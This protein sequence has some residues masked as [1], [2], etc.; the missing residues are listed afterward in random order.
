MHNT[1]S[2]K[3]RRYV[4]GLLII[5]LVSFGIVHFNQQKSS[6]VKSIGK[7]TLGEKKKKKTPEEQAMFAEE[8]LKHEFNLQANP[9]T[10]KIPQVEKNKEFQLASR[11]RTEAISRLQA[12]RAPGQD[13]ILRG[14][15]NLGGR[16]RSIIIDRADASGQTLIAGGVSS[17][18]FR[19]TDGGA[20]W[21]KVSA[22]S[23]IH[24]VTTIAQDPTNTN[25]WY[26]GTGELRGNSASLSG[27]F[28]YGQGIWQSTDG[29]LSWTQM[30]GTASTQEAFDSRFD[31]VVKVL[32][33]PTTGDIFA[34]T[35][36]TIYRYDQDTSTW[37]EE[38]A[39]PIVSST[40]Q[41]TDVVIA[42]DGSV[43]AAFSGASDA[44]V[45][46]VWT[47]PNGEGSWTRI[48]DT[49]SPSGW[50]PA[51]AGRIVLEAT[52]ANANIVYALYDNGRSSNSAQIESDFWRY[53][54]STGTWTDFSSKLPDEDGGAPGNDPF[55]IQGGYDLVVATKPDDANFVVIGGTNA[56]K[57][58]DIDADNTF[59][60]IGGYDGPNNYALY[61]RGGDTHHPDIHA[62]AFDPNNSSIM[63]SGT[64][65]GVHRTDDLDASS[66]AWTNLNNNYQTYQYYHVAMDPEAGS[67]IVIGG[68]QDNGTT[69]GGIDLGQP[70]STRMFTIFGGD[71]VSVAIS[72]DDD[73]LPFFLGS[74]LGQILRD[75]PTTADITPTGSSSQFVTYFYL[76]PDNNNALY[77]AGQATLYRTTDSNTVTAGS[78]D[79]VG[80]IANIPGGGTQEFIQSMATT[81]GAYTPQH[82][83]YIGGDEG[84]LYRLQDPQNASNLS[85]A[86]DITPPGV[87]RTFPNIVSGIATHPTNPDIVIASYSSYGVES[88]WLTTN[89]TADTPTWTNVERNIDAF[90]IR[91]VSITEVSNVTLY[92][93]GTARGLYAGVN[94]ETTDWVMQ[95]PDKVG[96]AVV[97]SLVSRPSDGTVLI[98]TH[99]NGMFEADA[100]TVLDSMTDPNDVDFDGIDN[101]SDNCPDFPNPDQADLDGDLLGDVCDDDIDGDGVLNDADNC[102]MMD[103]ADQADLDGD[104]IGDVCDED[105]DGDGVLNAFDLCP[106]TPQGATVDV[107]GCEI[108][109]LPSDNFSLSLNSET[110]RN[111]N[112]GSI[113][114]AANETFNY[115]A[116]LTGTSASDSQ[117]FTDT[118]TFDQLAADNYT[119]CITIDTEPDYEICFNANITEPAPLN[120]ATRVNNLDNT[121][122]VELSGSTSYTVDFNGQ[123]FTTNEQTLILQLVENQLNVLNISTDKDCQG[124]F[125]E[126]F[127]LLQSSAAVYPNPVSAGPINIRVDKLTGQNTTVNI[128]SINGALVYSNDLSGATEQ[129]TL[130]VDV[131]GFSQGMYFAEVIKGGTVNTYR[132]IKQ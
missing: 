45:K 73:C 20:S 7:I 103:N 123:R 118:V 19:T 98:G 14:P 67:D 128:Y 33:H 66:V 130:P 24:N 102:P 106:N 99:G 46:G 4:F 82:M 36:G 122:S 112:N 111:N 96:M 68:A 47:S 69:G 53:D 91:S 6:P 89:A 79:N 2:S 56:Y 72:R 95:S 25:T 60:R 63:Y 43:Y 58:E 93:I 64:D 85:S 38:L 49:G 52:P 87:A 9:I 120:V 59:T 121:L 23:D 110:C 21:T 11:E 113:S 100:Q 77:Y 28:Y 88:L 37:I 10:G 39:D 109:T 70:D 101:A 34:A 26:Y 40:N 86:I 119:V 81:R 57:I 71:G 41:M 117:T 124:T 115:T 90:S 5:V 131:S 76:D 97:S 84:G 108:F 75:C 32:V 42:A 132:F 18:V 125:S 94:P 13:Y 126:S 44:S 27:S 65:G 61:N 3:S 129:S 31:F 8:R 55:A 1:T 74:Q 17:G 30:P 114:I 15:S 92:F 50:S 78:W 48:A 104:N 62:F 83:L 51:G 16:T 107:D 127:D 29:G 105:V 12:R 80:A 54:S 22:N 35:I 116:T